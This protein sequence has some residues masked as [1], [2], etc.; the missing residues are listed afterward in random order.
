ME[1][2]IEIE[3]TLVGQARV[4]GEIVDLNFPNIS[5]NFVVG[6]HHSVM[7]DDPESPFLPVAEIKLNT[8]YWDNLYGE[9]AAERQL[10]TDI[11]YVYYRAWQHDRDDQFY[12]EREGIPFL[13]YLRMVNDGEIDGGHDQMLRLSNE[14]LHA[15]PDPIRVYPEDTMVI[16]VAEYGFSD[17][18]YIGGTVHSR[19]FVFDPSVAGFVVNLRVPARREWLSGELGHVFYHTL[20]A[21][22]QKMSFVSKFQWAEPSSLTVEESESINFVI[23]QISII[24][25]TYDTREEFHQ[26]PL[27]V[28]YK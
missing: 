28:T 27:I 8:E 9:G 2:T 26:L 18:P 21:A 3:A 12:A 24:L 16:A 13:E 19:D 10:F 5:T 25:P 6:L 11:A 7:E 20:F 14:Y 4:E 22:L 1:Q 17:E 15:Y 23:S